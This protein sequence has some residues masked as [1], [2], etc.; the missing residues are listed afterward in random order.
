MSVVLNIAA[1]SVAGWTGALCFTLAA[2]FGKSLL[3]I[4][5]YME[6]YGMVRLPEQPVQPRH[7]W[8][9]NRRMTS[10]G[11]FNLSRHSHHHAQGEVPYQNLMPLPDAPVM[12]GGYLTT[13][14]LTLCP[15]LWHKLM[16]SKLVEWDRHF[17]SQEERILALRANQRSG[18]KELVDYDPR[19]WSL[20]S[21]ASST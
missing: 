17:A 12:I 10:W 20:D 6:H 19:Q 16:T 21:I 11:M 1:F 18:I 2:L 7:S 8:N 14:F 5:N 9:T 13:I 3:E 4:V 15:P